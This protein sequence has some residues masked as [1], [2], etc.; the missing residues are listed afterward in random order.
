MTKLR[1]NFRKNI[2]IYDISQK[3]GFNKKSNNLI[4]NVNTIIHNFYQKQVKRLIR[5]DILYT[6]LYNKKVDN[7]LHNNVQYGYPIIVDLD[8]YLGLFCCIHK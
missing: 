1:L 4:S 3:D 7:K 6:Q 8:F 2:I 5:P